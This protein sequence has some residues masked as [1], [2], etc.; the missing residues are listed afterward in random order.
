MRWKDY[1]LNSLGVFFVL[2]GIGAVVNT[3]FV[4]NPAGI[5][6]FCYLGLVLIGLGILMRDDFLLAAQINIL[7]LPALIW[8]VDFFYVLFFGQS[9]LGITDYFFGDWLLISK[10]IT[11]QHIFTIPLSV[12]ALWLIGFTRVDAWK[13]SVAEIGV[14]YVIVKLFTLPSANINCVYESCIPFIQVEYYTLFWFFSSIAM[15][16]VTNIILATVLSK[17]HSITKIFK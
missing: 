1:L 10:L 9:L 13:L 17:Y 12:F 15:I 2:L 14:V 6:W 11:I 16:A 7:A 3:L 8:I 4:E 5:F